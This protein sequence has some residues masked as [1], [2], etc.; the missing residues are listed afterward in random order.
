MVQLATMGL[1]R[2]QDGTAYW[3]GV[4]RQK[5]S[6]QTSRF[7]FWKSRAPATF[8]QRGEVNRPVNRSS[9]RIMT[10]V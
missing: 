1:S 3:A 6:Q 2:V 10:L 5:R 7:T 4:A 8:G 9:N